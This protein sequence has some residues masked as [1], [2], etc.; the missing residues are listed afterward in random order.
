MLPLNK[1]FFNEKCIDDIKNVLDSGWVAGQGPFGEKL[2]ELLAKSSNSKYAI[3]TNNCTAAL[4]LSLLAIGIKSGDEVI[5]SDYTFPATG[6][7]VMYCGG[8]PR[9][10]DVDLFTYNIDPN[11]IEEKINEKTKAIIVVHTF[12]Q[13]ARMNEIMAIGKK[14]NLEVIEDAACAF[15]AMFNDELAGSFGD[16]GT[17]S[18]HGRKNI[19][20]GEGGAVITDNPVFAKKVKS[21]SSFGM[22][23]AMEREN[24][25][26]VPS[27]DILGFNYKL[28]DINA[29]IILSQIDLSVKFEEK[30]RYL[31]NLYNKYL[32]NYEF[33]STPYVEPNAYHVYQT[34]AIRVADEID[35]DKLISQLRSDGIQ[36]NIGTYASHLQP[37][38][39]SMDECP[40]SKLLFHK[41]LSLPLF[42]EMENSQVRFVCEK[43]IYNLNKQIK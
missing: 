31:A 25:F 10:I 28:S 12:G 18:F 7:T 42:F 9:F 21:L 11:L 22:K 30:R 23:T 26:S 27:F 36:T 3:P 13:V 1:P 41:S 39:N 24:K 34:Y 5:I 19:T 38:Y 17:F 32:G 4:H 8:I 29:S 2:S 15:G 20:C 14:Y 43:L 40:N 6:H 33:L 35:R 16:L 37:V